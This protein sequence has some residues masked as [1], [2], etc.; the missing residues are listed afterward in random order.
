MKI[1]VCGKGGSG[2]STIVSLLAA[3]FKRNGRKVII[4]DSD[5]SN[6]NLFWTLGFDRPARPLMDLVGGKKAVQQKM[7]AGFTRK[8]AEPAM[9]IWEMKSLPSH[10][11]PSEYVVENENCKLVV[12]GKIH[13]SLEGCACPMGAVTREFL[14]RLR[15]ARDEI[16]VIDM[17]AGIEHFGRGV[18]ASVDMVLCVVEPSLESIALAK[19][20]IEL[21]QGAGA[22]FK[23]AILN[24]ISS[25]RQKDTVTE[26]LSRLGV[27]ILGT[28]A[29][30]S[31]IQSS[32]L[33]GF[34]LNAQVA[35][36]D[37][38]ADMTSELLRRTVS[39]EK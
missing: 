29:Y 23:G 14:K 21:T 4:L 30:D 3:G 26:K 36:V 8:E 19:K 13:Q 10:E 9:T 28:V 32:C 7:I 33:D 24:K 2:K 18:E 31:E 27:P 5:E 37:E 17:E 35:I 39:L 22:V 6:A 15:P 25:P 12:T 1:C 11:I 16:V 20:V 38:V 34:C